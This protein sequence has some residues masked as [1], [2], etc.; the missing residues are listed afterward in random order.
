MSALALAACLAAGPLAASPPAPAPAAAPDRAIGEWLDGTG[1]AGITIAHC[2]TG[3][4]GRITW[5]KIPRDSRGAPKRDLRNADTALRDR[6]LCGLEILSGLT[7]AGD[8]AWS[9][10]TIYDPQNGK[11]YSATLR[12]GPDGTLNVRGYVGIALFGRSETWTRPA[13]ALPACGA[14]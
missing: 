6:P 3:L 9:G 5:L 7:P 10:G 2:G 13:P 14:P 1:R 11:T 12:L 8:D 4:C